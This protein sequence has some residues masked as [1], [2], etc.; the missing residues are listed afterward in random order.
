V[1]GR[2]GL[3]CRVCGAEVRTSVLAG[4]NLFW[5]PVCQ[6][7]G[8]RGAG[9]ALRA[10]AATGCLPCPHR[11]ALSPLGGAAPVR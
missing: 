8:S 10:A 5:C 1:Y 11:A 3:P 7:H 4:R 9:R 6:P 2:A